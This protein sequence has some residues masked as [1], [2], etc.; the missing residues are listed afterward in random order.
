[1]GFDVRKPDSHEGRR[2]ERVQ[3]FLPHVV[4]SHMHLNLSQCF[5]YKD[6]RRVSQK[7]LALAFF[8]VSMGHGVIGKYTEFGKLE[9]IPLKLATI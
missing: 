2:N 8:L 9:G 6:D 3:K 1:M 7:S 5:L 4:L